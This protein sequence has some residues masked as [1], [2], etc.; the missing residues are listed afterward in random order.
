MP[1]SAPVRPAP[2]TELNEEERL[3]QKTVRRFAADVVA[4]MVRSMEDAD[5]YAPGLIDKLAELGLM[6]I[7]APEEYG[8]AG[9]S[10]FEAV[11]AVEAL[12][13]VDASVGLVVDIQNTL[14]VNALLRW[15]PAAQKKQWL[16][17]MAE[18]MICSYALSEPN[19]GSD[20]FAM[21]TRA[22]K[23]ETGYRLY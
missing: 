21:E 3:L 19:S 22:V 18:G 10:F 17:Q 14:C 8:G 2:V 15:G 23:T 6:A 11:L 16:P 7:E 5:A 13:S 9:G 20:A 4:P 12:S 1:L